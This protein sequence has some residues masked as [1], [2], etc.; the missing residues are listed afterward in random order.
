MLAQVEKVKVHS[1]KKSTGAHY[2]PVELAQFLAKRLACLIGKGT[3][4]LRIMDPACGDGELLKALA[5]ELPEKISGYS[6]FIG[7]DQD[8]EA[9]ADLNDCWT[10]GSLDARTEDF[11]SLSFNQPAVSSMFDD[12]SEI[13]PLADIIIANPPYVRTQVLGALKAQQLAMAFD[14]TGRVDLYH[15]FLVA[16]TNALKPGG[17]LGVITSNRFLS[18][19]GGISVRQFLESNFDILEVID[20]GDTK[21]FE[22]AVLPAIFIG[23]KR[24]KKE[25]QSKIKGRFIRIYEDP[26]SKTTKKKKSIYEILNSDVDGS[27]MVGER[28]YKIVTGTLTLNDPSEPW[29]LVCQKEESWLDRVEAKAEFSL[30]SLMK[31]KVGIKTTADSVFI[32][33]DWDTLAQEIKPES[34]LLRPIIDSSNCTRWQIDLNELTERILYPYVSEDGKKRLLDLNNYPKTRSYFEYYRERLA[35]RKYIQESNREWYEIWVPH[36]PSYWDQVML[37]TPDISPV[38][39]FSFTSGYSLVNGNCYWLTLRQGFPKEYL[40]LVLG[41]V[42]SRLMTRYHDLAFNNKL[43]AGRRRYL[44]QYIQKYPIPSITNP[45]AAELAELVKQRV[46]SVLDRNSQDLLEEAIEDTVKKLYDVEG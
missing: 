11:L 42:N 23:R 32:R 44:T 5:T 45:H 41:I 38:P 26:G 13:Q 6:Q 10:F 8:G 37:V 46:F 35:G 7:F 17:I 28:V 14:L 12:A 39:K 43:Y 4:N 29:K 31:I 33:K 3:E 9:I 18:T 22:A 40:F 25:I 2:T 27:Y 20:L 15:A 24:T 34:E 36:N 19:R 21:L 30:G 1:K 16:M